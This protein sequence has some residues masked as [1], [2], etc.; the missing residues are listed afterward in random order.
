MPG[1]QPKL[2]HRASAILRRKGVDVRV[3]TPVIRVEGRFVTLGR[4]GGG[5][6]TI[7]AG[8]LVWAGGVRPPALLAEAG[9]RTDPDGRVPVNRFLQAQGEPDI[10]VIGDSAFYL[11]GGEPLAATASNALRQ[12]EYVAEVLI[13]QCQGKPYEPY[14]PTRPGVLV[15]LGGNDGVGDALGLPLTGLPAG[16]LKEGVERWYLTTIG[17]LRPQ[18]RND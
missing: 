5:E 11:N 4:P 16:L 17:A 13:A 8:T 14:Q 12:G 7:C 3:N 18:G 2:S 1:W 9:L 10:F 6:E 15:S